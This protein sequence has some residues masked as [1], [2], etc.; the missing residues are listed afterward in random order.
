MIGALMTSNNRFLITSV[1]KT[2]MPEQSK[3]LP[4]RAAQCKYSSLRSAMASGALR[5]FKTRCC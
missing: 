4:P 5:S 1:I 2:V 3:A